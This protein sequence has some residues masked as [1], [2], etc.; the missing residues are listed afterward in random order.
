MFIAQQRKHVLAVEQIEQFLALSL[1]GVGAGHRGRVG[2]LL[3]QPLR[4]LCQ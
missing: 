2:C 1:L 3:A 4:G